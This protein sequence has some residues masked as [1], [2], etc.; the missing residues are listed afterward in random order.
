MHNQILLEQPQSKETF[1]NDI[2]NV[3]REDIKSVAK[4][5]YLDTIYV[6]T[7]GGVNNER[8]IL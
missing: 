4:Q 1:I 5:A 3:S 2:Q 7:K 6:L 8:T